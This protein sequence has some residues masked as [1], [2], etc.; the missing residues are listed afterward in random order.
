[1]LLYKLNHTNE[2]H[3]TEI[4]GIGSGLLL[5]LFFSDLV[6]PESGQAGKL[7]DIGANKPSEC[8]NTG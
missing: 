6:S 2:F 8:K 3:L 7:R 1:M 5:L 4:R